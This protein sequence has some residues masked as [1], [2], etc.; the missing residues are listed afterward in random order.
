M[1]TTYTS[2]PHVKLAIY[3]QYDIPIN[4]HTHL[5]T[6]YRFHI[7]EYLLL[8]TVPLALS[9]LSPQVQRK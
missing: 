8:S 3:M 4:S 2:R 5:S 9:Q 1:P 6:K 7:K